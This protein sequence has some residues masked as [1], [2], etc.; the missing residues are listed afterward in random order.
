[1]NREAFEAALD[2][3]RLETRMHEFLL[4]DLKVKWHLCRRD[5]PTRNFGSGFIIPIQ[6]KLADRAQISHVEFLNRHV[7]MWFRIVAPG[8]RYSRIVSTSF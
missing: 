8:D 5:G 2:S 7:D 3:R 6:F 4:N 1:M